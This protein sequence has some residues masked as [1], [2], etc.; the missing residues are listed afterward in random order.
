MVVDIGPVSTLISASANQRI[1]ISQFNAAQLSQ[2]GNNDGLAWSAFTWLADN[3]LY[4]TKGRTYLN[5]QTAP[6]LSKPV[7]NQQLVDGRMKSIPTGSVAYNQANP[8]PN[9]SS[10]VVIEDSISSGNPN[11]TSGTSYTAAL[12]GAYG[13]NFNGFFQGNPENTTAGNF[14]S[15]GQV[16]RSDFYSMAP[17]SGYVKGTYLGYFEFATDGT[18]TYVAYPSTVPVIQSITRV[19][20]T[21][22]ITYTSGLYGTYTLRGANDLVAAGAQ[23]N[24]PAITTLVSGNNSVQIVT[25]TTSDAIKFYTITAQ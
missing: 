12:Q 24:W 19:G 14:T 7:G 2:L 20:A 1:S 25:D 4:V 18:M 6:W 10:A 9:N 5:T 3:T 16:V 22:T 15:V 17:S 8:N 23:I 21:T 11:Y 13:A